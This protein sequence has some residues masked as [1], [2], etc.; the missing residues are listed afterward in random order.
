MNDTLQSHYEQLATELATDLPAGRHLSLALTALEE[1]H[2]WA[3]KAISLID[4]EDNPDA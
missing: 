1:S 4:S 2:L 3:T